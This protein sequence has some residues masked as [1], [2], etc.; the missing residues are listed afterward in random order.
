[1]KI[2]IYTPYL[3]TLGGGE[4]YMLTIA[5]ILA[6]HGNK[7]VIESADREI[8]SK[9]EE[10]FSLSLKGV[11]VSP[12][13]KKG[14]G[15]DIMIWLSDGSIPTMFARKNIIHFQRPFKHVDGKSLI[16]RIKLTRIKKVIVN[17]A[18]TKKYIDQE[19][20]VKSLVLYPPIDTNVFTPAK[21]KKQ[22]TY[23]GR[24]SQLEQ[25]KRQDVLLKSFIKLYPYDAR[26][27]RMIIAGGSEIGRTEEVDILK[28]YA[29]G[30]PVEIIESPTFKSVRLFLATSSIFWSAAGYGV[31]ENTE[32]NRME[33]FGMTVVE[34]MSSGCVPIIFEGGGHAEIV[35]DGVNGFL[36]QTPQQLVAL[37]KK[38]IYNPK[39][40]EQMSLSAR[41]RAQSFSREVFEK[42][43]LSILDLQ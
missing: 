26:D 20:P 3:S 1:M 7:V 8:L 13:L 35:E 12:N 33:H 34:A 24:F 21:K 18:F 11:E 39:L 41:E 25:S 40:R 2:A 10:R 42:Q 31:D 23:I 28:N 5:S 19:F 36:W 29:V 9:S 37:T 30:H 16:N 17:S 27:W 4:R 43:L 32:P 15:Y 22:I 14:E 38:L 6:K